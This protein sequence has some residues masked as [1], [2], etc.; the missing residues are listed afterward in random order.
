MIPSFKSNPTP[1]PIKGWLSWG[2]GAIWGVGA[3]PTSSNTDLESMSIIARRNNPTW[4]GWILMHCRVGRV[5]TFI[6]EQFV[7]EQSF[8]VIVAEVWT[9]SWSRILLTNFSCWDSNPGPIEV[10]DMGWSASSSL[11]LRHCHLLV[12][13]VF[14]RSGLD[15]WCATL[16]KIWRSEAK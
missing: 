10:V 14:L 2:W 4:F 6:T 15:M 13:G 11:K 9:H 7:N 1:I 5:K 8:L 12:S 3:H 16:A